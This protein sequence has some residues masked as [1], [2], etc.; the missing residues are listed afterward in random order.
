MNQMIHTTAHM[1][2]YAGHIGLEQRLVVSEA[3]VKELERLLSASEQRVKWLEI[4]I[5]TRTEA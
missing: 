2:N 4:L 5:N 3:R 1:C